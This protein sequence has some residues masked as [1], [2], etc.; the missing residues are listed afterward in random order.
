MVI[1]VEF[2]EYIKNHWIVYFKM[3]TYDMWI[4]SQKLNEIVCVS[5]L[6][7]WNKMQT[8]QTVIST[9]WGLYISL[10]SDLNFFLTMSIVTLLFKK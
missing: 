8:L 3:G 7:V 5:I 1:I 2:Y 4:K 10:S 9:D 6:K